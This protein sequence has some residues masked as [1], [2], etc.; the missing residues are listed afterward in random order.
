M[1]L[2]YKYLL[3]KNVHKHICF[4]IIDLFNIFAVD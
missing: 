1:F 3:H 4:I 2:Q